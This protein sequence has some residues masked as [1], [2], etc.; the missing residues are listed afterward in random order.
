MGFLIYFLMAII[1]VFLFLF[2]YTKAIQP[3]DHEDLEDF[4]YSI[5][6]AVIIGVF[7]PISFPVCALGGLGWYFIKFLNKGKK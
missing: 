4:V 7:W 6:I 3:I 1:T 5:F 2:V